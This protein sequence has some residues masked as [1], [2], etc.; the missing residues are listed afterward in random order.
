L[1]VIAY[2]NGNIGNNCSK[3][4]AAGCCCSIKS[5][6]SAIFAREDVAQLQ[7]IGAVPVRNAVYVLPNSD[8]AV[9]DFHW[10]ARE[11]IEGAGEAS[12]CEATFIEGITNEELVQLFQTARK[13]DYSQLLDEIAMLEKESLAM[14]KDGESGATVLAFKFAKLRQRFA[15]LKGID[16]F[17]APGGNRVEPALAQIESGLRRSP[18]RKPRQKESSYRGRTWVTRKGIHVDRIASDGSSV[19]LSIRTRNLNAVINSRR[20]ASRTSHASVDALNSLEAYLKITAPLAGVVTERLIHP[21]ALVGPTSE[22]PLLVLQQ[23]SRLRVTVAVPRG[24]C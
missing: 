5:E 12:V 23:I 3:D 21:G 24:Q 19:N 6:V 2:I 14:L 10:V 1:V 8:Q 22:T 13:A 4:T 16:F 15:D 17:S 9:E 11:I 20:Q 18:V 7:R